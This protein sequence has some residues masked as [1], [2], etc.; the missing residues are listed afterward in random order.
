MPLDLFIEIQFFT[1]VL[2]TVLLVH[3]GDFPGTGSLKFRIFIYGKP[4][5]CEVIERSV[6]ICSYTSQ[7]EL[8]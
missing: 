3:T 5:A 8:K 4:S 2:F 6:S 7:G 1:D